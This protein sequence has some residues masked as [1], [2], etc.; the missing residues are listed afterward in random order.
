[1]TAAIG[2]CW[3]RTKLL[4]RRLCESLFPLSRLPLSGLPLHSLPLRSLP[5]RSFLSCF[6]LS[7]LLSSRLPLSGLPLS[8]LLGSSLPLSCLPLRSLPLS[9]L[10]RSSLPLSGF[11]LHSSLPFRSLPLSRLLLCRGFPACRSRRHRF[12][13]LRFGR[14]FFIGRCLRIGH[15]HPHSRRSRMD[16]KITWLIPAHQWTNTSTTPSVVTH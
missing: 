6:S 3:S 9:R 5:L 11:P 8:R 1:M 16:R 15:C 12:N 4:A 2:E 10:L 13:L 14:H 7:W